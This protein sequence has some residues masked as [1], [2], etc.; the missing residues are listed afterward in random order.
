MVKA[1]FHG[2]ERLK[3]VLLEF[4]QLAQNPSTAPYTPT[5]YNRLGGMSRRIGM[6]TYDVTEEIPRWDILAVVKPSD[7]AVLGREG[8]PYCGS[9]QSISKF[10]YQQTDRSWSQSQRYQPLGGQASARGAT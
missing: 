3:A 1:Y 2:L 6:A 4:K 5:Q 9:T 7:M 8:S 10:H